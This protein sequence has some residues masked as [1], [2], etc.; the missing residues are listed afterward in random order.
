[1]K[2][3]VVV[4]KLSEPKVFTDQVIANAYYN[5]ITSHG[6]YVD[7]YEVEVNQ[8]CQLNFNQ[9]TMKQ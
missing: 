6:V 1:M 8:K 4:F 5:D 9:D 3:Y 2:A 7:F